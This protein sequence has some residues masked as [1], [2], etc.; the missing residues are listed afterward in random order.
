MAT[1]TKTPAEV[2]EDMLGELAATYGTTEPEENEPIDEKQLADI[3]QPY[4][5][6]LE[7]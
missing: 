4:L 2:L 6:A 5:D 1:A 3:I 7:A